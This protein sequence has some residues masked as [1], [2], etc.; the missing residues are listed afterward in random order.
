MAISYYNN[1]SDEEKFDPVKDV[2]A[3]LVGEMGSKAM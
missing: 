1:T 2:R 3:G